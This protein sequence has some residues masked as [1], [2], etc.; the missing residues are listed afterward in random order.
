MCR[1]DGGGG[2][3]S[4]CVPPKERQREALCI[5]A[6]PVIIVRDD[7]ARHVE[8]NAGKT[9][10]GT[11]LV[12][13]KRIWGT[14]GAR[15]QRQRRGYGYVKRTMYAY[16]ETANQTVSAGGGGTGDKHRVSPKVR[17]RAGAAW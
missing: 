17:P 1:G 13:I 4:R 11:D 16:D 5:E 7:Y 6:L 12:A 15:R 10:Y 3:L 14:G 2:G 8:A 9:I